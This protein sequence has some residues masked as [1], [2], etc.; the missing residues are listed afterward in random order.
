MIIKRECHH[1]HANASPSHPSVARDAD[2]QRL[3]TNFP[4]SLTCRLRPCRKSSE[5][6]VLWASPSSHSQSLQHEQGPSSPTIATW[7]RDREGTLGR[8]VEPEAPGLT[9][10]RCARASVL[11]LLCGLLQGFRRENAPQLPAVSLEVNVSRLLVPR[12]FMGRPSTYQAS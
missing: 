12:T 10:P 3:T 2:G 1:R 6:K 11:R 4:P 9:A 8:P 7:T 5:C